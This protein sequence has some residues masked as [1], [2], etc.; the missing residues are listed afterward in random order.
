[1]SVGAGYGKPVLLR[2]DS[3]QMYDDGFEFFKTENN[4]W[5]VDEV[6]VEFLALNIWLGQK[7]RLDPKFSKFLVFGERRETLIRV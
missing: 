3:K 2:I 6:P 5:L 4:V 7:A 1:M